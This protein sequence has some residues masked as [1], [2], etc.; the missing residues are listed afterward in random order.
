VDPSTANARTNADAALIANEVSRGAVLTYNPTIRLNE[1]RGGAGPQTDSAL[2]NSL[3]GRLNF[4]LR[5]NQNVDVDIFVTVQPGDQA[6][7]IFGGT[8]N[9]NILLYPG[10]GLETSPTGGRVPFNHRGGPNGG[11]GIRFCADRFPKIRPCSPSR[12]TRPWTRRGRWAHR[13]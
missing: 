8:F 10:F 5:W 3:P 4:V 9:P 6:K 12:P 7:T 2:L 13:R 11:P 1:I